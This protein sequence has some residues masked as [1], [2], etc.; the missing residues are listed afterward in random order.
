MCVCVSVLQTLTSLTVMLGKAKEQERC[1][2]CCYGNLYS[3]RHLSA[4]IHVSRFAR[5][6]VED[7]QDGEN[8]NFKKRMT[9]KCVKLLLAQ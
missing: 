9:K 2:L 7:S 8:E 3:S 4:C 1:G 6:C 5:V